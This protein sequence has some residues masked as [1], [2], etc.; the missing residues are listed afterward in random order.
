MEYKFIQQMKFDAI[1]YK[2]QW[3]HI[4]THTD[5]KQRNEATKLH[6]IEQEFF[7]EHTLSSRT[8]QHS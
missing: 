6:I 8:D 1:F 2:W 7:F 4:R 3:I 5:T